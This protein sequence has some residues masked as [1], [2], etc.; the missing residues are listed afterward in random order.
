MSEFLARKLE[1]VEKQ[2]DLL[3]AAIKK[4]WG[5]IKYHLPLSVELEVSQQPEL[6]DVAWNRRAFKPL[7]EVVLNETV[8]ILQE[9]N[10]P[11]HYTT[12]VEAVKKRAEDD[13]DLEKLL[14]RY[15]N[16]DLA[17]RV[18]ALADEKW[19]VRLGNGMYFY[20]PKLAEKQE[21]PVPK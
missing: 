11:V 1:A 16:P 8:K 5:F 15:K 12:I 2:R 9:V 14:K 3:K 4:T 6:K 18:R 19:L 7:S 17:R 13:E 21:V 20:G 10:G